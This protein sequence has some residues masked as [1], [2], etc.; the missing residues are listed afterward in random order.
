[1]IKNK[2]KINKRIHGLKFTEINKILKE[3]DIL[4]IGILVLK[5]L[6]RI[7]LIE[8][9]GTEISGTLDLIQQYIE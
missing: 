2:K 4:S 6:N 8:I 7:E 3:N 9:N 1:M 5:V